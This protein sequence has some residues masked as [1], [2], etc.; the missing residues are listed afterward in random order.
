[1][2]YV[3]FFRPLVAQGRSASSCYPERGRLAYP[4]RLR[5]WL[6]A[7]GG[8]HKH[9][10]HHHRHLNHGHHN[11]P[12]N[13]KRCIAAGDAEA[14]TVANHYRKHRS[15]VGTA[16]GWRGVGA[17]G[18]TGDVGAVFLPLVAQGRSACCRHR[19]SG[20]LACGNGL[21]RWLGVNGGCHRDSQRCPVAGD[22]VEVIANHYR[23]LITD[24]RN[25]GGWR[26][27]GAGGGTRDV[28][29]VF[30]PLVAQGRSACCRQRESGRLA[31]GNRLVRWLRG[32]CGWFSGGW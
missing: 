20:R 12:R 30:P 21:V 13:G 7:D 27:V 1:M 22:F 9:G 18:G 25:A 4:N 5:R 26:G 2:M 17:G 28:G 6:G 24:V 31:F 29:A 32:N 15:I 3:P 8:G 10:C 11:S 14:C 19:E 16:D 23:I